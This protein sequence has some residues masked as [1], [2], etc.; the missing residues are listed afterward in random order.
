MSLDDTH[1]SMG[2]E[3]SLNDAAGQIGARARH[4]QGR[5]VA[6]LCGDIGEAEDT[7]RGDDLVLRW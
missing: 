2:S 4:P 1:Y 6:T 3:E 7:A 5:G